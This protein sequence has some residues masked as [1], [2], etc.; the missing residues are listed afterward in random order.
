MEKL[1]SYLIAN[2]D[3]LFSGIG[4]AVMSVGVWLVRRRGRTADGI[5][6]TQ[7]SGDN[8][9]NVQVSGDFKVSG[10]EKSKPEKRK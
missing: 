3:W 6:Q 1:I 5:S 9:V 7:M 4:V 8:S 2:K 10:D